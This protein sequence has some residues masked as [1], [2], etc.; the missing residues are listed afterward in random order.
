MMFKKLFA[1]LTPP[2]R[3]RGGVLVGMI[4]VMAFLDMF[5]VASI[6]PFVAVLTN[7]E[8]VQTNAMLNTAFIQS[9][10]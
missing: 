9:R 8:V 1:L 7:P 4:L 10:H 5:G 3:R 2:E 6:L